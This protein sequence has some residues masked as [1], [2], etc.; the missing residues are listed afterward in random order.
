MDSLLRCFQHQMRLHK[1]R[2]PCCMCK[3][4]KCELVWYSLK[5]HEVRRFRCFT[6][7]TVETRCLMAQSGSYWRFGFAGDR[8][9][10]QVQAQRAS[11]RS[12]RPSS[13]DCSASRTACRPLRVFVP[14]NATHDCIDS[15]RMRAFRFQVYKVALHITYDGRNRYLIAGVAPRRG[16]GN[17]VNVGTGDCQC[18]GNE[19]L[20]GHV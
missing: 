8:C 3:T 1:P 12:H 11:E 5:T 19:P 16:V 13:V 14:S 10:V 2:K 6:A 7:E 4:F 20:C 17:P 15:T 9:R 18:D